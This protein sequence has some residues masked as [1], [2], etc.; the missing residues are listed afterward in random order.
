M[1]L[2]NLQNVSRLQMETMNSKKDCGEILSRFDYKHDERLDPDN[3]RRGQVRSGWKRI[4]ISEKTLKLKLTWHNLGYRLKKL[5]GE[6]SKNEIDEI[7]EQFAEHYS[8]ATCSVV[9]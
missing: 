6:K 3:L 4:Y 9:R 5:W 7:Y 2:A 8:N 1:P